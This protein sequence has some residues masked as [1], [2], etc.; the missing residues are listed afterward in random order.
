[1]EGKGGA[2][3]SGCRYHAVF[4]HFLYGRRE[5]WLQQA[6]EKRSTFMMNILVGGEELLLPENELCE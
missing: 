5:R 3:T 6:E 1:M 4:L 2:G